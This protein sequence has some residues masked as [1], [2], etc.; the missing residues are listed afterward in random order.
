[1]D[2]RQEDIGVPHQTQARAI[3]ASASGAVLPRALSLCHTSGAAVC[4]VINE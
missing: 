4:G 3:A 2:D 1:M